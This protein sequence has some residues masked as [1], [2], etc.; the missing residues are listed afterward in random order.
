MLDANAHPEFAAEQFRILVA[1]QSLLLRAT[2][3]QLMQ[4]KLAQSDY[5]DDLTR[6]VMQTIADYQATKAAKS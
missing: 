5:P 6:R 2:G 3:A 1:Q 4:D